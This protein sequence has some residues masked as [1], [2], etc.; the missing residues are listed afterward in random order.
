[1]TAPT[2]S[3]RVSRLYEL[4]DAQV[5]GLTDVLV[6]CVE[7]GASVG[8]MHPIT[9]DRAR[10]FWRW[11]AHR[12]ASGERA[13]LIAEDGGGICGTVQMIMAL[14]ENQP[15]RAEVTKML[16]HRRAR[17]Q[18]VG[19]ALMRATEGVARENGKNLLVLDAVT[20]GEAAQLYEKLGWA[21]V[22]DVP[23]FALLPDGASCS[24]TF[25]YRDLRY[26][27]A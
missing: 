12:V 21:R 11:T 26:R 20:G 10:S 14:P 4:D 9:H 2:T 15:H 18:G 22:G 17:R 13:I 5:D 8:F 1:M 3:C 7:G 24:T 23:N 16:V 6:D 25:Y 27:N 19:S